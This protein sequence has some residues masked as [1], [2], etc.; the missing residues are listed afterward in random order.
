VYQF[1]GHSQKG[2]GKCYLFISK[3]LATATKM[4]IKLTCIETIPVTMIH[5]VRHCDGVDKI[6]IYFCSL[7]FS[8]QAF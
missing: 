7:S 8:N 6:W 2:I 4:F 3:S 1:L 5:F